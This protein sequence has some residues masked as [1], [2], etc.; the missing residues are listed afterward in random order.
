MCGHERSARHDLGDGVRSRG[1]TG[2][3]RAP[4]QG[5]SPKMAAL[6]LIWLNAVARNNKITIEGN[7]PF[8]VGIL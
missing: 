5:A 1:H 2:L 8:L 7:C 4:R 6:V 3:G